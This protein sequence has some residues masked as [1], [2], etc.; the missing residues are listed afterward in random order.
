M[1][2][3]GAVLT[4]LIVFGWVTRAVGPHTPHIT[5]SSSDLAVVVLV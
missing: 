3:V 4:T 2:P 1:V 5:V